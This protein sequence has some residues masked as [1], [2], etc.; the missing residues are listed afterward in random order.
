MLTNIKYMPTFRSRQQEMIVLRNFDF[1]TDMFPLIEIVKEFDRVQNVD[2]QKT[3]EDIYI[4]FI[5]DIKAEKVFVDIPFYLKASGSLNKEV[6]KFLYAVSYKIDTRTRY[7][8]K[9]EGLNKKV[10]P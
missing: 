7:L 9:F 5:R 10:I 8:M 3:F 4:P 2:S 1:G 6:L